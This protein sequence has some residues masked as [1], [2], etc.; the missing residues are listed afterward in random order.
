MRRD[1]LHPSPGALKFWGRAKRPCVALYAE[2][3]PHG[4]ERDARTETAD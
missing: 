1:S 3:F 4:G 2:N